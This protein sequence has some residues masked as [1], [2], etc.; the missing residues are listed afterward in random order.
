MSSL[1]FAGPPTNVVRASEDR[2]YNFLI[3]RNLDGLQQIRSTDA[4]QINPTNGTATFSDITAGV[5][6]ATTGFYGD[7]SN[8][9][10]LSV[11]NLGSI[12][13]SALDNDSV[14]V[15]STQL[16]LG[17][18]SATLAGLTQVSA[19]NFVGGGVGL[20]GVI[21]A[22]V[23]LGDGSNNP[24]DC[25]LIFTPMPG[26]S[27]DLL[28]D[29][30]LYFSPTTN[31]LSVPRIRVGSPTP[32]AGEYLQVDSGTVLFGPSGV[33]QYETSVESE[34]AT[35]Y[36]NLH[37]K[38]GTEYY[39]SLLYEGPQ[40]RPTVRV[41]DLL[42]KNYMANS[43]HIVE[44]Q[45]SGP[46]PSTP[47]FPL[48]LNN[49]A[50]HTSNTIKGGV[51]I[52]F[53]SYDYTSGS[54]RWVGVSSRS[55]STYSNTL[56]IDFWTQPDVN[57]EPSRRTF[58]EPSGL[59]RAYSFKIEA[60]G[61][62]GAYTHWLLDAHGGAYNLHFYLQ[63]GDADNYSLRSY[64]NL[65]GGY[66][67]VSDAKMKRDVQDLDESKVRCA[68]MGLRPVSYFMKADPDDSRPRSGF[69]AQEVQ[70]N[71]CFAHLVEEADTPGEGESKTLAISYSEFVPYLVKVTQSLIAENLELKSRLDRLEAQ[72]FN[73]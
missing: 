4:L 67:T 36:R 11:S 28:G 2:N 56:G 24:F 27:N 17:A 40:L 69:I 30:L 1:G 65:A 32:G 25:A 12:P 18:V 35:G 54:K 48:M 55:Y 64:I 71:P 73:L 51:G 68:L 10:N 14:T 37:F 63:T 58:I 52:K 66:V 23:S 31:T 60:T 61:N 41:P 8:I 3:V 29:A 44:V 34:A 45:G 13:N 21:A 19:T 38:L 6:T 39:L 22:G 47:Y 62:S 9:T 20:A 50:M 59:L 57:N 42:V 72:V 46:G 70:A 7:G 49:Q 26:P 53:H 33:E 5:V 43:D 16:Q 15:G